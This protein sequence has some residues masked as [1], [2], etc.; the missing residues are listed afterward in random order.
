MSQRPWPVWFP[1]HAGS[2]AA[3]P[4]NADLQQLSSASNSQPMAL[5][6]FTMEGMLNNAAALQ[7]QQQQQ[8]TPGFS[9]TADQIAMMP[10]QLHPENQCHP[11][12]MFQ[13]QQQQQPPAW[14]GTEGVLV[15]SQ[16]QQQQQQQQGAAAPS[17][18]SRLAHYRSTL[19]SMAG[20]TPAAAVANK[21][22][23]I[24]DADLPVP[25]P[26]S[27][28]AASRPPKHPP[29][30]PSTQPPCPPPPPSAQQKPKQQQQQQQQLLSNNPLYCTDGPEA[31]PPQPV[32]CHG[33]TEEDEEGN[34]YDE[35]EALLSHLQQFYGSQMNEPD[36]KE[37]VSPDGTLHA[38]DPAFI[39]DALEMVTDGW[40]HHHH[41][42]PVSSTLSPSSSARLT[43]PMGRLRWSSPLL[44]DGY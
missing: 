11:P 27:A 44:D 9:L 2:A 43:R 32:S 20:P 17:S 25:E 10:L 24:T 26:V 39:D 41:P 8:Q 28:A 42:T 13:Q 29:P 38:P 35:D 1:L 3:F 16:R 14:S 18:S 33:A 37:N 19:A 15:P 40:G 21:T 4:S 12:Q 22:R 30:P 7:Q 31:Q 36:D 34:E 23:V 6:P 5:D